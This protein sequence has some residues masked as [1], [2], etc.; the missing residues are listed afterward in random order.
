MFYNQSCSCI[1]LLN[2]F[3]LSWTFVIPYIASSTFLYLME[4]R[5][6]LL[7][8]FYPAVPS[9]TIVLYFS[10]LLY[11]CHLLHILY[12]LVVP[13]EN[14]KNCFWPYYTLLYPHIPF[15]TIF[16]QNNWIF[17]RYCSVKKGINIE[18]GYKRVKQGI[19]GSKWFFF[20]FHWVVQQGGRGHSGVPCYYLVLIFPNYNQIY[21][22]IFLLYPFLLSCIFVIPYMS[23]TTL[24][25]CI[26]T[27]KT[28]FDPIIPAL[29]SYSLFY[30]I[31]TL[32]CTA[33]PNKAPIIFKSY[34]TLVYCH[35][36][37]YIY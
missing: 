2:P 25:Y 24:T 1:S 21:C 20:N 36:Y 28:L 32:F 29:H 12:H 6:T 14:T 30:Y 10:S 3:L 13:Y 27:R 7:T 31:Y 5:K 11:L 37:W 35:V 26:K 4:A 22:G 8:L 16:V 19:T 34:C 23:S 18:K 17:V 15:F 9:Y 33:I